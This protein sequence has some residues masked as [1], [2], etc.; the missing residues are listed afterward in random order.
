METK[1]I[2]KVGK[3][4]SVPF[5]VT[6]THEEK[7][8]LEQAVK[9][10]EMEGELALVADYSGSYPNNPSM[11]KIY[12]P[13]SPETTEEFIELIQAPVAH[14]YD[15]Y[16]SLIF[17]QVEDLDDLL[18]MKRAFDSCF[19]NQMMGLTSRLNKVSYKP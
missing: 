2:H 17:T 19:E 1:R 5:L 18:N 8:F 13:R 11:A 7:N 4:N 10:F 12:I 14:T 6:L 16:M 3:S 15:D 9:A